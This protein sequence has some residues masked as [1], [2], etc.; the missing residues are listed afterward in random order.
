MP[1]A[2]PPPPCR[3]AYLD[4]PDEADKAIKP[5]VEAVSKFFERDQ[6]WAPVTRNRILDGLRKAG[7]PE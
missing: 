6:I 2:R 1:R 7:L 4:R 3:R 5:F